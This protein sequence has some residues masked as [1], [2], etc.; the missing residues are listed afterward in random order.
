MQTKKYSNFRIIWLNIVFDKNRQ[1]NERT[2]RGGNQAKY[3]YNLL[4]HEYT[5]IYNGKIM[6]HENLSEI[7]YS[8]YIGK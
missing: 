2:R 4:T 8:G 5:H 6:N 1:T 7:H 3:M